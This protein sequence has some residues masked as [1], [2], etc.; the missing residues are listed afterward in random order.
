M[1]C[2]GMTNFCISWMSSYAAVT[3][4]LTALIYDTPM[5]A[6]HPLSWNPAAEEAFVKIK[7]LLVYSAVLGLPNY[8]KLFIQTVDCKDKYMTSVFTRKT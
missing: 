7:Q 5:A 2:L 6:S 3:A 8:S 4:T 1:L